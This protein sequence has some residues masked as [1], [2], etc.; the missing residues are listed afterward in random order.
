MC[1]RES[2]SPRITRLTDGTSTSTL[3]T[4]CA[5]V[6]D[7]IVH[8]IPGERVLQAGDLVSFDCGSVLDGWHGD[9][10]FSV[11]LDGGDRSTRQARERLCAVTREAMWRGVA[12]LAAGRRIGDGPPRPGTMVG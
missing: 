6:N 9:A 11:V 2:A 4:I 5:S 3:A 1:T 12:A 10:A 7:E 8:G